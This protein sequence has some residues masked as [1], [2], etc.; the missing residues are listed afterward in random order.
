M[1]LRVYCGDY[2]CANCS[3]NGHCFTGSANGELVMAVASCESAECEMLWLHAV[4][5][6]NC[7]RRGYGFTR[8]H[9]KMRN[10]RSQYEFSVDSCEIK[11]RKISPIRTLK[12]RDFL[13]PNPAFLLPSACKTFRKHLNC[14][15]FSL[16]YSK[17]TVFCEYRFCE[18]QRFFIHFP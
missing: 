7:E 9:A 5:I 18:Q 3:R 15:L 2:G 4:W 10:A 1:L 11:Y 6:A 13:T 8:V 14:L 12:N 17:L 16:L